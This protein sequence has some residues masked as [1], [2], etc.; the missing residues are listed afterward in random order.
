M[1]IGFLFP[2]PLLLNVFLPT[3]LLFGLLLDALR[4]FSL[5]N[6]ILAPEVVFVL[7]LLIFIVDPR[8]ALAFL[9]AITAPIFLG[10][11]HTEGEL[12]TRPLRGPAVHLYFLT[13]LPPLVRDQI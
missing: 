6:P 3:L 2:P 10:C 12:T 4:L 8:L 7:D 5:A 9:I 1:L 11:V 13:I